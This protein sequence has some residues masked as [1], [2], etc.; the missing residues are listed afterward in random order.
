MLKSD[1]SAV[2]TASNGWPTRMRVRSS[3]IFAAETK[4]A[5]GEACLSSTTRICLPRRTVGSVHRSY[6]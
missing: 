1:M 2:G 3:L 4:P 5:S 6:C